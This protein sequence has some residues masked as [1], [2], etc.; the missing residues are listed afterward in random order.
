MSVLE[1][2]LTTVGCNF[3]I[4]DQITEKSIRRESGHCVKALVRSRLFRERRRERKLRC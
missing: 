2:L 3:V 4:L 1:T